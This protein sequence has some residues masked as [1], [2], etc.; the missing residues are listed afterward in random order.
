MSRGS[1]MTKFKRRMGAVL[2]LSDG[3][4]RSA[5]LDF[6]SRAYCSPARQHRAGANFATAADHAGQSPAADRSGERHVSVSRLN[7]GTVDAAAFWEALGF[8]ADLPDGHRMSV[9]AAVRQRATRSARPA[10]T[11][12]PRSLSELQPLMFG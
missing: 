8:V 3:R 7:A 12:L 11:T 10:T 5:P 1:A 6:S 4:K 2:R 9:V